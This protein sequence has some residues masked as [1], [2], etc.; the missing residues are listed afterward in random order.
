M[1][2]ARSSS[3][4]RPLS[5]PGGEGVSPG[6]ARL[7]SGCR[8]TAFQLGRF[9]RRIQGARLSEIPGKCMCKPPHLEASCPRASVMR[10]KGWAAISS[11]RKRGRAGRTDAQPAP[12]GFER[13]AWRR[14]GRLRPR[15]RQAR[16]GRRKAA[17]S[18]AR[19]GGGGGPRPDRARLARPVEP[20]HR[21][22]QQR[23]NVLG[24]RG[25]VIEPAAARGAGS[26]TTPT[27]AYMTLTR[28]R[29]SARPTPRGFW[30]EMIRAT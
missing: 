22:A 19:T 17:V 11:R 29:R 28:F 4:R 15:N 6:A 25:V 26:Q 7:G 13:G 20:R 12:A 3:C 30:R 9:W 27:R 1:A 23:P 18:R 10:A 8:R 16:G 2:A 14:R 21:G 24:V 5:P